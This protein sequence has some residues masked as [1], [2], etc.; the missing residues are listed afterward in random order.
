[1]KTAANDFLELVSGRKGGWR[2]NLWRAALRVA[3]WG[4]GLVA[5]VRNRLYDRGWLRVEH[6]PA[7]VISVG[8]LTV[9]GTGKTP[10]VEFL[11][12]YL[13]DQGY[14]VAVLSRGYGSAGGA[15][16][17][18]MLLEDNLPNVPH[19]I[20]ADRV[21]L[22]RTAIEELESE[23]LILDDGFQHRRL[24][25][26][27]DLVLIDATEPWGY[28]AL[29]PRGLLRESTSALK[30]ADAVILT[31]CDLVSADRLTS[32]GKRIAQLTTDKLVIEAE[33][34]PLV[35]INADGHQVSIGEL[36]N[37]S[38]IAFCGIGNPQAFFATLE[39]LGLNVIERRV[40]ADHY[41]YSREDVRELEAWAERQSPDAVV[42]TTQKDLV[43]LRVSKLGGRPLWALKIGMTIRKGEARLKQMLA[44]IL[45]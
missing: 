8:N 27:L 14:R 9:G 30:R 17:E 18:A 23:I 45:N 37:R 36:H 43:K 15:N 4:Y 34:Q 10:C 19:L 22:A 29:L 6:V 11:A 28:G 12:R 35:W 31:R 2:A 1:M 3:S 16:D 25:R 24:A 21:A 32:I 41:P 13:N 20:G 39:K 33:H 5:W 7:Q 44:N 26:S 40:Y 42:L 38:G